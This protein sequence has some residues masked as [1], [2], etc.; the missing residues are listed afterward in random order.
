[1]KIEKTLVLV[2]VIMTILYGCQ[3]ENKN[4]Y[5]TTELQNGFPE[6]LK[7][8]EKGLPFKIL[9]HSILESNNDSIDIYFGELK[10]G[11][12]SGN[13]IALTENHQLKMFENVNI[14]QNSTEIKENN[15]D[16]EFNNSTNRVSLRI[17][18][19]D[20][21][22]N[23]I[24]YSWIK[25]NTLTDS[26]AVQKIDKPL[27]KGKMFPQIELIDMSGK[28]FNLNNIKEKIIVI[29]WWATWCSP[30]RKEIPGLN[31]LVD[32]Y[33]DKN[34]RF[35]SITDD[36]IDKISSFLEKSEFKY[37][38]TFISEKSRNVFGNSYPRNIVIDSTKNITLY[39]EGGNEYVWQKIDK[40]LTQMGIGE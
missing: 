24:I 22:E 15:I 11:K 6:I 36:S 34:I 30:C 4:L 37:D 8:I 19:L 35:I 32:K 33:S 28:K 7:P 12:Q 9:N 29:N 21:L 3:K 23:K 20:T 5:K 40:H 13:W 2:F 39:E 18:E 16:I 38:I 14:K 31:K 25:Q 1:M 17:K 10:Q 27:L 26:L